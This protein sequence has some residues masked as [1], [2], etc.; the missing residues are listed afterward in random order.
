MPRFE[1]S[2]FSV[3][4]LTLAVPAL[5]VEPSTVKDTSLDTPVDTEADRDGTSPLSFKNVI[6]VSSPAV[7]HTGSDDGV[8]QVAHVTVTV[9]AIEASMAALT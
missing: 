5:D 6:V 9:P 8:E 4:P 2:A 3:V 1:H 7:L